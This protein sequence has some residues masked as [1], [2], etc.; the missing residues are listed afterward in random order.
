VT[1]DF[2]VDPKVVAIVR[3]VASWCLRFV[4]V[5]FG[6][7]IEAKQVYGTDQA[8]WALVFLGLWFVG[9]PPAL[10]FDGV[11][12]L[13]RLAQIASAPPAP[14]P[15]SPSTPFPADLERRQG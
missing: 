2:E 11:W 13:A 9:V 10:W 6:I 8:Q 1:E 4:S 14:P 5:G 3:F 15:P 12:R 7:A